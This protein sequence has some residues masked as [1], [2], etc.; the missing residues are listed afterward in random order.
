MTTSIT[1]LTAQAKAWL[2]NK[3]EVV[4]YVAWEFK[5]AVLSLNLV[6]FVKE[7][8]VGTVVATALAFPVVGLV[9]GFTWFLLAQTTFSSFTVV[10]FG[11][12]VRAWR[13]YLVQDEEE[14]TAYFDQTEPDEETEELLLNEA[15]WLVQEGREDELTPKHKVAL[16]NAG[17]RVSKAY[18][19]QDEA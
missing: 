18:L 2:E 7:V 3:W 13:D 15:L 11:T 1:T 4:K 12:F 6:E 19:V 8:L 10:L 9:Y 14:T 17:S 5:Q 16:A